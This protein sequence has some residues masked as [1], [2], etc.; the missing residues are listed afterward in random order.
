[1]SDKINHLKKVQW[2]KNLELDFALLMQ[3]SPKDIPENAI[4]Q[5]E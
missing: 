5:L 1:M 3:S 2:Q 4:C